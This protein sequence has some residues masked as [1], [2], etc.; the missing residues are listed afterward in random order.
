MK[1]EENSPQQSKVQIIFRPQSIHMELEA[2]IQELCIHHSR[3]RNSFTARAITNF[4]K[5]ELSENDIKEI[6]KELNCAKERAASKAREG[7]IKLPSSIQ[8]YL[9]ASDL[10]DSLIERG[11]EKDWAVEKMRKEFTIQKLQT[12]YFVQLLWAFYLWLLK[13]DLTIKEIKSLE[14]TSTMDKD[15]ELVLNSN[16]YQLCEENE[17]NHFKDKIELIKKFTDMVYQDREE[18][19]H[20]IEAI[21]SLLKLK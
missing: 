13:K 12:Q 10:A 14:E 20:L 17:N 1:K 4:N 11:K 9:S 15:A 16:K 21:K 18:D 19:R 5:T 6:D 3:Q 7:K 2:S 8:I